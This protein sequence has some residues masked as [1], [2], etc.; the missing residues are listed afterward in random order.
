M[1][2]RI[3]FETMDETMDAVTPEQVKDTAKKPFVIPTISSPVD[4]LEA[5]T[6]FQ[7]VESGATN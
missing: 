7:A 6:F 5:T 3:E 2:D 1:S 4:V